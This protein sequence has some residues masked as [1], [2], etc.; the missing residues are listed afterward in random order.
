MEELLHQNYWLLIVS[1]VALWKKLPEKCFSP[2]SSF[3]NESTMLFCVLW[4]FFVHFLPKIFQLCFLTMFGVNR[5]IKS[6]LKGEKTKQ[7]KWFNRRNQWKD[8]GWKNPASFFRHLASWELQKE[9]SLR[10][11]SLQIPATS[12]QRT[13]PSSDCQQRPRRRD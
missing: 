7:I 9:T 6:Q 13:K 1:F 12:P 3:L 8:T 4:V 2:R 10:R 5:S 11:T